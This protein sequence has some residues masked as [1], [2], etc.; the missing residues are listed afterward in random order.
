MLRNVVLVLLVLECSAAAA[1]EH[2]D[3]AA[4][5][6][7]PRA[8]EAGAY[9]AADGAVP[10]APV[11]RYR[12]RQDIA[13]DDYLGAAM[14]DDDG[15]SNTNNSNDNDVGYA[16]GNG[17]GGGG[18]NNYG[19]GNGYGNGNA[20]SN[21]GGGNPVIRN[22]YAGDG[23]ASHGSFSAS[24]GKGSVGPGGAVSFTGTYKSAGVERPGC[25]YKAVMTDAEIA[26]CK[27]A[28]LATMR[29]TGAK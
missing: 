27:A 18:G 4:V 17:G 15:A 25:V 5:H 24:D 14:G 29:H 11:T 8:D 28:S 26:T 1:R 7:A 6:T 22:P 20:Y 3:H 12:A 10:V 2:V 16:S 19:N 21:G 9:R 13:N 23:G